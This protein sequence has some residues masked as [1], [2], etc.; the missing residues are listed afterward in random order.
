MKKNKGAIVAS[1]IVLVL[2]FAASSA[3]ASMGNEEATA[4]DQTP[5]LTTGEFETWTI[6]VYVCADNNLE[7]D[8]LVNLDQM[9]K[10]GSNNEVK[11][12]VLMDTTDE[13]GFVTET[14]WYFV[15]AGDDHIN[16]T[17][18]TH[19]CDCDEVVGGCPGE[20]NMADGRN[21]TQFIV[22][23]VT[24][25]PADNYVLIL[26]D[27]GG[28][29]LGACW[30][31]NV[32]LPDDRTDRLTVDEFGNAI[33]AAE[34]QKNIRLDM[35]AFD[36]CLM[37]MVEVA[38]ELRDLADYMVAS[39]TG[40]PVGGFPYHLFLGPLVANPGMTVEELGEVMVDTLVYYY[41]YCKGEGIGGSEVSDMGW[42]GVTLSLIDL[43]KLVDLAAAA[44]DL[45]Y[46]IQDLIDSGEAT[47]GAIV[48]AAE[49]MTPALEMMGQ[50]FAYTDLSLFASALADSFPSLEDEAAAV[51][52]NVS[53]AVV[54]VDWTSQTT[55]GAFVTTGITIY[56]PVSYGWV[57][58]FYSYWTE[59][60][61][62]EAG[63]MVYWGLDFPHDTNWDEFILGFVP[64]LDWEAE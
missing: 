29:W 34:Q 41:G 24:F 50:G 61:A 25:A 11:I 16:L 63:E 43:S 59:E 10:I 35:I 42:I 13:L 58:V 38:Y 31:D 49:A 15:E 60:E 18:E 44:D 30:D 45:S 32:T 4:E 20:L 51:F 22:D 33:R 46:A 40:I 64:A 48:H 54:H 21:L 8:G 3:M 23:A 53:K 39:V 36:A 2:V 14:H 6:M 1:M 57:H 56:F 12:L 52:E 37:S 28:G 27:H 7:A 47:H 26:W 9:E 19:V 55:G 62:A 5:E 17:T